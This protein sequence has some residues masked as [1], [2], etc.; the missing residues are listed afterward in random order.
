MKKYISLFL[1]LILLVSAASV[2]TVS[3]NAAGADKS[4]YLYKS[5]TAPVIDG[6]AEDLWEPYP[7]SEQLT[8]ISWSKGNYTNPALN[9]RFKALWVENSQDPTMIDLYIMVQ[10]TG[11]FDYPTISGVR[12]FFTNGDGT[13]SW[14]DIMRKRGDKTGVT[15]DYTHWHEQGGYNSAI[16]EA[17]SM[18][19]FEFVGHVK[20]EDNLKLDIVVLDGSTWS[21]R[22]DYTWNGCSSE[23]STTK[24]ASGALNMMQEI[25]NID[26]NADV[27]FAIDGQP[28]LSADK[29]ANNAVT[30]PSY[31]VI[32]G[33]LIGWKDASGNLYPVG[34]SYTV[35]GSNQV[36]LTGLVLKNTDYYLLDG[37]SILI[38][39]PTAL[40]YEVLDAQTATMNSI[41]SLVQE[42][43]ALV[44]ET[45]KLTDAILADRTFSAAEL[46]AASITYEK[47]VFTT[48]QNGIHYVL[49]NNISDVKTSY[50]ACAYIT[51]QFADGSTQTVYLAYSAL[52]N[53][54]SV[55]DV[56]TAAYADRATVPAPLTDTISY[57]FKVG[58][59]FGVGD[60]TVLSFSPYTKEQLTLL[61]S[62]RK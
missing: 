49:K 28:V 41:A 20:K 14:T 9:A 11:Y 46:D 58:K 18:V 10:Y 37:A 31:E 30:L 44:V 35:S 25:S 53:A 55:K 3:V 29:G 1:A 15:A 51:V 23:L 59:D 13:A 57:K 32:G 62:F 60:Y 38:E 34:G 27:L 48:A 47:T 21:T 12:V 50:S 26:F 54:R 6:T 17:D 5:A 7:W 42:K 19:T 40:R 52:N 2:F 45:S 16:A 24:A 43:G 36:R 56:A 61:D 8:D 33:N 4:Y 39:E 22:A